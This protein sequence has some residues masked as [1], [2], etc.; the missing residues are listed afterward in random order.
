MDSLGF[1]KDAKIAK[2]KGIRWDGKGKYGDKKEVGTK[3]EKCE[4]CLLGNVFFFH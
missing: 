3:S 4:L 1:L 2:E